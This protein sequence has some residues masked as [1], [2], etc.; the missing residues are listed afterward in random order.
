MNN[1]RYSKPRITS[2]KYLLAFSSLIGESVGISCAGLLEI[3]NSYVLAIRREAASDVQHISYGYGFTDYFRF[4]FKGVSG[5]VDKM[6]SKLLFSIK[7]STF[8]TEVS[9]S[10]PMKCPQRHYIGSLWR[11]FTFC[12]TERGFHCAELFWRYFDLIFWKS[13]CSECYRRTR[14]VED[15]ANV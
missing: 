8:Q 7:P 6:K 14:T 2:R 15:L 4:L 11:S 1:L 5:V 10:A 9:N 12:I 3:H 13:Y